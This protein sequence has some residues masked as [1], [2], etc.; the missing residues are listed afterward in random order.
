[1]N[2]IGGLDTPSSG[3]VIVDGIDI[4]EMGEGKLADFRSERIGFVFQFFNLI[5][6]LTALE[7]VKLPML[8]AEKLS[9]REITERAVDLLGLV[10]LGD[11]MN[12]LPSQMSGG[13]QQRVAI[14][15]ALAN[16]PSL[17]IADEP[18]GNLDSEGGSKI[19]DFIQHL[20]KTMSQTCIVVTHDSNVA[21]MTHRVVRMLDGRILAEA[22]QLDETPFKRD[23][24][25]ER[26]ELLLAELEW[27]RKSIRLEERRLETEPDAYNESVTEYANRW[28]R[29]KQ[30]IREMG[31]EV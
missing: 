26:R 17:V 28:R 16:E 19:M 13:Q 29:L 31:L 5:P 25:K 15:R 8:F 30:S 12:H 3:R 21:R 24:L 23:S 1:M 18:T 7:N 2:I 4:T 9:P 11:R 27:L 10:G 6:T 22:R 20:N 14:A